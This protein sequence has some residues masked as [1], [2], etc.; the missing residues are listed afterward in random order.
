ML[1]FSNNKPVKIFSKG[2]GSNPDLWGVMVSQFSW[3]LLKLSLPCVQIDGRRGYVNKG[4][5]QETRV[6]HK[7]LEF[8][9][10]TEFYKVEPE[11]EAP[12]QST[13]DESVTNPPDQAESNQDSIPSD[14]EDNIEATEQASSQNFETKDPKLQ[15]PMEVNIVFF[16]CKISRT[17][18]SMSL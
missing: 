11:Q 17:T 9:V 5:I 14:K 3:Y 15:N 16:T 2:A 18:F 10:P 4:H 1:S 7:N 8:K 12:V 13:E 6:H